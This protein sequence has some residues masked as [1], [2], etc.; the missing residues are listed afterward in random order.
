MRHRREVLLLATLG[1]TTLADAGQAPRPVRGDATTVGSETRLV[2]VDAIVTDKKG[3]FIRDL[4]PTEFHLWEGNKEQAIQSVHRETAATTAPMHTV[5]LF[6]R[7]PVA[8]QPYAREAAT[9]FIE[10]YSA[11]H[12]QMAI[13]NYLGSG[14]IKVIQNFTADAERLTQAAK[15]MEASGVLSSDSAAGV[16]GVTSSVYA[17]P[18]RTAASVAYD[19]RSQLQALVEVAK[20][21]GSTPGRKAIVV[22]APTVNYDV[23]ARTDPGSVGAGVLGSAIEAPPAPAVSYYVQPEDMNG[24]INAF[25]RANVAIYLVDVRVDRALVE[26]Q[27]GPLAAATGGLAIDS[28]K[29]AL[30]AL[31]KI[32]QDQEE[33]YLIAYSPAPPGGERCH[34]VKVKVD[35]GGAVVRART[36][37][38]NIDLSDPLAG[39]P[40]GRELEA[41]AAGSQAGSIGGQ[42]QSPFFY[43]APDRAR[44][45][46]TAEIPAAAFN[47][48]KQNGR[49]HASLNVLG[50]AASPAGEVGARFSD[51]VE[52]DFQGK[53]EVEQFKQRPYRYEN[54]LVAAA[55]NY[56]LKMVFSSDRDKFGKLEAPLTIEPWDGEHFALS[57]IALSKESRDVAAAQSSGAVLAGEHTPFVSRGLQFIPSGNNRYRKTD[58]AM[59]YVEI[60]EPLLRGPDPP[61][62]LIQLVV[63]NRQSGDVKIDSGRL[64]MTNRVLPGNPVIPVGL[65]VPLDS[66]PP[67]G[68]AV[69]LK[70]SDSAG[71]VS[72]VRHAEFEVE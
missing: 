29:D 26:N 61:K 57:A 30:N 50:I 46:I 9:R 49:F 5:L 72:A 12:R 34:K 47:F 15:N 27:L 60:Y 7:I 8:D 23:R 43:T 35:R 63:L 22:L 39:T 13:L 33:H 6:G 48:V 42:M 40:A 69:V 3:D 37:Y 1:L 20:S 70:A 52:F 68:Y 2:L 71:N 32:A 54:D 16:S 67:G 65:K 53:N 10:A 18:T 66:L 41:R 17:D 51:T 19:V 24:A 25:N 4:A 44:V 58:P 21:L 55:G 14:G 62:V 31:R 28:S 59:L 11:P 36:E 56:T 45:H 64:D 38:C